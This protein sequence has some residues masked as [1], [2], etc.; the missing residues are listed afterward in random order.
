[1]TGRTAVGESDVVGVRRVDR[2]AI[3]TLS[4]PDRLNAVSGPLYEALLGEVRRLGHDPDVRAVV[5]TGEGRAFS[6]GADLKAHGSHT[7]ATDGGGTPGGPGAVEWQRRYVR[8]GQL[9]NLA[10]QRCPKPVVAAVNGHAIGGGLELALSCDLLVVAREAKLRFPE[11]G[12]GTFVGGGITYTLPQRVGAGRARELLLLGRF[13]S[14]EESVALGL[15]N[16]ARDAAEVLDR[17]LEIAGELAEKAPISM[18][19]AKRLLNRVL[20]GQARA[21]LATEAEVLLECMGTRDWREGVAAFAEG[22]P[23]NFVGE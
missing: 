17:A 13:F 11:V 9:A 20:Q 22:R 15:A 3:L 1:M 10:I 6:V 12:L 5:I 4:R 14:G 2:T 21:A 19:H 7:T 23:P 18:R 16:E 8:L